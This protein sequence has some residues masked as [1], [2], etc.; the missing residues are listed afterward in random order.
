[1]ELAGKTLGIIGH[2]ALG[3]EV[4]RLAEAFGMRVL[5]AQ[6]LRADAGVES[7]R[8]PLGE[9]LE[10]SDVISLHCPLSETTQGLVDAR[11]LAAM[12]P[13]A[14]LIN[15]ARGGLVDP[16]ALRAALCAGR[17]GGAA[18]DV[19]DRE[20]PPADHPLLDAGIPN[21]LITPHSAWVSRESRQRLLD[22]IAANVRAWRAGQP[23]NR[24][25]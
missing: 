7:G 4:A 13:G 9:L 12:K 11:F 10:A 25:A 8:V 21:L 20:P 18:L 16:G 6:S 1:M 22:A 19:L 5:V 2:G 23:I 15:T 3:R 24:V 14:L 17:L